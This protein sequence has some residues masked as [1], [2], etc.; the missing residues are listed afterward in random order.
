MLRFVNAVTKSELDWNEY[1]FSEG[2]Q[3]VGLNRQ[4]LD[5]WV[6]LNAGVVY[7]FL[8][9]ENPHKIID[10]SPITWMGDWLD[11]SK[12]QFAAQEGDIT[13]YP[14][15]V[16]SNDVSDDEEFDFEG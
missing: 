10:V 3:I 2:R 8:G 6:L 9:V 5:E 14:M 12:F 13:D 7:K 16:V 1:L 15:N 4:L 11:I